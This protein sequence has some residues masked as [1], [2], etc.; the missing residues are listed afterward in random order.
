MSV[1]SPLPFRFELQALLGRAR[2]GVFHTPHGALE[3]PVFAPVGT[4]ATVKSIT[5]Q[6]LRE[7]GATL[8]L[9]N[10]YHLYL[11]PGDALVAEM[12]GLHEFMQWERPMLTD[13]GGF[14]VFSLAEARKVDDDG[15]SFKSHVDGSTHRFT[16][17]KAVAIQENLGADIIM[18][19]DECASPHDRAYSERAMQRTHAWLERCMAARRRPD[20]A[21][22]GIVQG[23]VFADLRRQ[24]AEFVAAQ[25]LPGN[26]IGGLSVGESKDEMYATLEVVDAVLPEDRPRYLMGVGTPEDLVNGVLRGVDIFDCV[27]PTRLARHNAAM[28]R[29]GRLNMVNAAYAKDAEPID[30]NCTCYACQHFSRAYIRHLVI[31]REMLSATLLSIHN[32]HTLIQ[33]A[34]E[35]RQAI[36]AG[37]IESYAADFFYQL[38]E[39]RKV[40][41]GSDPSSA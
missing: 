23:G 26:A 2:A 20:Q 29:Y 19:F 18:A 41:S 39:H 17:E 16:P 10:T 3:T 38:E 34:H 8:V 9:S 30:S 6:Q 28:T 11:R 14:Q 32:L 40:L 24:S 36:L 22:F 35:L 21:L 15:V 5:P 13:S 25:N 37:T 4:Q 33:I 27:L 1:E 7:M 12:G 31:A